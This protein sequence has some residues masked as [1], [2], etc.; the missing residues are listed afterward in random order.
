MQAN[1]TG[2]TVFKLDSCVDLLVQKMQNK[3]LDF[4][5]NKVAALNP[6]RNRHDFK[7]QNFSYHREFLF[8][9][10]KNK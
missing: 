2:A 4:F 6:E 1:W 10:R 9:N 8:K 3:L 5:W 7:T